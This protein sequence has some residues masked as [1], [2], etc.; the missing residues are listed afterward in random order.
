MAKKS[1]KKSKPAVEPKPFHEIAEAIDAYTV[2]SL[3]DDLGPALW[4]LLDGFDSPVFVVSPG[5]DDEAR[6]RPLSDKLM[7]ECHTVNCKDHWRLVEWSEV[8][9]ELARPE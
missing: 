2:S 6:I 9:D 8:R 1:K 4:D 7:L 5:T 3:M